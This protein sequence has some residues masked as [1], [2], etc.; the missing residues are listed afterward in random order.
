[1]TENIEIA[2]EI[3]MFLKFPIITHNKIYSG[4]P[5]QQT[6]GIYVNCKF[7]DLFYPKI[8]IVDKIGINSF[9]FLLKEYSEV[10]RYESNVS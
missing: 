5:Q 10:I 4:T 7:C 8:V 1:M 3:N 9:D 6:P 2:K